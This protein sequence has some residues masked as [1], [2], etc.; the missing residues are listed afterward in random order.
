MSKQRTIHAE[1]DEW[2][3]V[4]YEPSGK[5]YVEWVGSGEPWGWVGPSYLGIRVNSNGRAPVTIG[6]AVTAAV[7]LSAEHRPGRAGGSTFDR[8]LEA[9]PK[10]QA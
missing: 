3:I 7:G 5:W 1:T 9:E 8:Q 4:R 10:E 6:K 2:Q